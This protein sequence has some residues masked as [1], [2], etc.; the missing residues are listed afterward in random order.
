MLS[1]LTVQHADS[2]T[3][4]TTMSAVDVVA[5]EQRFN[6]PFRVTMNTCWLYAAWNAL[7]RRGELDVDWDDWL[8]TVIRVDARDDDEDAAPDD[9][10]DP[11][12]PSEDLSPG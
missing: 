11:T 9:E 8:D 2:S 10:A 7:S 6:Q 4:D 5:Y 12:G 1:R 3:V